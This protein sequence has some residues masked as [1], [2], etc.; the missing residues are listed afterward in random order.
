MPCASPGAC[1]THTQE[2]EIVCTHHAC[3]SN[4]TDDSESEDK[5]CSDG[6]KCYC[7]TVVLIPGLPSFV[8]PTQ[9]PTH[10]TLATRAI[11]Y[12]FDFTYSIWQPPKS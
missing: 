7:C 6:C 4:E 10:P 11:H 1:A 9:V 12:H 8:T 3:D 2:E 5:H